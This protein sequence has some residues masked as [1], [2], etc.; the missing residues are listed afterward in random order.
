MTHKS[1]LL[2]GSALAPGRLALV[3]LVTLFALGQGV[4][5]EV[6][7]VV[8][9][10]D[11]DVSF[12]PDVFSAQ[13]G[14][15]I[16]DI[17]DPNSGVSINR[18]ERFDVDESGVVLNNSA[19]AG[20]SVLAGQIAANQNFS[21]NG[22][23][24]IVNEVA[25]SDGASLD[26]TVEVFGQNAD[27]IVASPNGI[28]CDGCAFI[29]TNAVTL[30]TGALNTSNGLVLEVTGGTVSVENGGLEADGSVRL[31]G[32]KAELNGVTRAAGDLIVSGGAQTFD[33]ITG[34]ASAR[35]GA[36]ATSQEYAVDGTSFGVAQAGQITVIGNEAGL[37]VRLL[38]AVQAG[39]GGF[40]AVSAGDLFARSVQTSGN[41]RLDAA[42]DI[43]IDRDVTS[44]G[45]TTV[46]AGGDVRLREDGGL[47]ASGLV[48][49]DGAG[50]VLIE[51][52]VQSFGGISAIAGVDLQSDG[53][54]TTLGV[55]SLQAQRN[56]DIAEGRVA[57]QSA[58]IAAGNVASIDNG[59]IDTVERVSVTGRDVALGQGA[60]FR[61]PDIMLTASEDFING[62]NLAGLGDTLSLSFGADLRNL[63]T[64]IFAFEQ[65]DLDL[66]GAILNEGLIFAQTDI[67]LRAAGLTNR[68]SG[69]I[70]A[71]NL[72]LDINGNLVN[73]GTIA[74]ADTL[75]LT[76]ASQLFNN[77]I[78]SAQTLSLMAGELTNTASGRLQSEAGALTLSL[79]TDLDNAGIIFS[80]EDLTIGLSGVLATNGVIA[81]N[82]DG[83]LDVGSFEG[84]IDNE[85]QAANLILNATANF[86]NRGVLATL[87]DIGIFT[88]GDFENFGQ[89][90]T[91]G[92]AE[93]FANS[94]LLSQTGGVQ[95]V[96]G[97]DFRSAD[98]FVQNGALFSGGR[99]RLE[100]GGTFAQAGQTVA[101]SALDISALSF[102]ST[103][104]AQLG[105]EDISLEIAQEVD[106]SGLL[107][108]DTINIIADEVDNSGTVQSET[109]LQLLIERLLENRGTGVLSSAGTAN[110][111][112]GSVVNNGQLASFG[113][114][115]LEAVGN[116]T[117]NGSVQSASHLSFL[118]DGLFLGATGLS[119]ADSLTASLGTLNNSGQLTAQ[120]DLSVS[121]GTFAQSGAGLVGAGGRVDIISGGFANSGLISAL[122]R[123]NLDIEIGENSGRLEAGDRI[124]L[125]ADGFENSASGIVSALDVSVMTDNILNRG[126]IVGSEL[127]LLGAENIISTGLIS[128]LSS[129]ELDGQAQDLGGIILGGLIDIDAQTVTF[130]GQ[131]EA[132]TGLSVLAGDE[133]LIE[134]VLGFAGAADFQ[135]DSFRSAAGSQLARFD[136]LRGEL[137][138]SA[139]G[140][141]DLDG[142]LF[143]DEVSVRGDTITT[144]TNSA[145]LAL[146]E[147]TLGAAGDLLVQGS[148]QAERISLIGEFVR[149]SEQSVFTGASEL[150]AQ[151]EQTKIDGRIE[152][153]LI[154]IL[155]DDVIFT[156][157][158]IVIG[159]EDLT[160]LADGDVLVAGILSAGEALTIGPDGPLA[161]VSSVTVS[162][163]VLAG[164]ALN[165]T[166]DSLINQGVLS[167]SVAS[168][169]L[170]VFEGMGASL[171]A[172]QTLSLA[173]NQSFHN[174]G[175]I[176][177]SGTATLSA[178]EIMTGS[179]SQI[180][181]AELVL[182][183]DERI[184]LDGSVVALELDLQ[185]PEL[186]LSGSVSTNDF[187]FSGVDFASI[188]GSR[189]EAAGRIDLDVERG[190]QI[191]GLLAAS[192]LTSLSA[193]TELN[194]AQTGRIESGGRL[195]VS[196]AGP[197]RLSG[198]VLGL[199]DI[200]LNASELVLDAGG[201]LG[202]I[203][204]DPM[205]AG[206]SISLALLGD[207]E[208]FGQISAGD[209]LIETG[210]DFFSRSGSLTQA[211]DN[212]SVIAPG[213]ISL[214]GTLLGE[215]S[216]VLDTPELMIL[217]GG[218][219]QVPVFDLVSLDAFSLDGSIIANDLS[220]EASSLTLGDEAAL[221][222]TNSLDIQLGAGAL[223]NAGELSGGTVS[224]EGASFVDDALTGNGSAIVFAQ[225]SL[226]GGFD[227]AD[228]S[229]VIG[230]SGTVDLDA[231]QVR[232]LASG[233]LL[234]GELDA[235]VER[236]FSN[237]GL[238]QAGR[239]DIR[240]DYFSLASGASLQA[241]SLTPGS[242]ILTADHV[243]IDG[244]VFS[245]D[246]LTIGQGPTASSVMAHALNG[247]VRAE[248]ELTLLGN[249]SQTGEVSSAGALFVIGDTFSQ[250]DTGLL[251]STTGVTIG[252]SGGEIMSAGAIASA[253]DVTLLGARFLQAE[254]GAI[255]S[256]SGAGTAISQLIIGTHADGFD[257]VDLDGVV[258]SSGVID[259]SSAQLNQSAGGQ[260][261]AGTEFRV[262]GDL[263]QSGTIN[264]GEDLT[265]T[266]SLIQASGGVLSAQLGD[267]LVRSGSADIE[268]SG[269]VVAGG[270]VTL[271]GSGLSQDAGGI[272]VS[273]FGSDQEAGSVSENRTVIDV[274]GGVLAVD[275]TVAGPDVEL[276]ADLLTLG[277]RTG[278]EDGLI[279]GDRNVTIMSALRQF[280][281]ITSNGTLTVQNGV[282]LD[283]E[284]NS[285]L[286]SADDLLVDIAGHITNDGTIAS[287]ADVTLNGGSLSQARDGVIVSNLNG[288]AD[289][290]SNDLTRINVGGGLLTLNGTISGPRVEI[291][292]GSIVLGAR[293]ADIGGLISAT[294]QL[295]ITGALTQSGV[296]TS[297][298]LLNINGPGFT[299]SAEGLLFSNGNLSI[300]VA[301]QI[302]TDGT[303]GS[304]ADVS[305]TGASLTQGRFGTIA[306][307]TGGSGGVTSL[308]AGAGAL[309]LNGT[310]TGS[311]VILEG[312]R[313]S[314]GP[315]INGV[316]GLILA[317]NDLDILLS[318]VL[319]SSGFIQV[320][321]PATLS[322]S[323]I[324]NTGSLVADSINVLNGS[325]LRNAGT[326]FTEGN[327]SIVNGGF[328][329]VNSGRL[330]VAGTGT[331]DID[332]ITNTGTI[333]ADTFNL[334]LD[335]SFQ[336]D[337]S[338][339]AINGLTVTTPGAI[340]NNQSLAANGSLTLNADSLRN[341]SGAV[342]QAGSVDIN[343]TQIA[344]SVIAPTQG[345]GDP[346]TSL[347]MLGLDLDGLLDFFINEFI[348]GNP[349][350]VPDS[351]LRQDLF[352][353]PP[354]CDELT[355]E[356]VFQSGQLSVMLEDLLLVET[357]Q[358]T[359]FAEEIGVTLASTL[360]PSISPQLENFVR[361]TFVDEVL[362]PSG[363]GT[364]DPANLLGPDPNRTID[365]TCTGS[366]CTISVNGFFVFPVEPANRIFFNVPL[367]EISAAATSRG[368]ALP[369]AAPTATTQND[370]LPGISSLSGRLAAGQ[371]VTL[372]SGDL[373][374]AGI[375]EA[376][377]TFDLFGMRLINGGDVSAFDTVADLSDVFDST[378]QSF[379]GTRLVDVTARR[380][381]GAG[382]NALVTDQ[383][384]AVEVLEGD[385]V[386]TDDLIVSGD[387]SL[388]TI[389]DIIFEADVGAFG[390]L[391]FNSGDD[392]VN[393]GADVLAAST[394]IA[395][396]N[397]LI[398][399]RGLFQA[400]SNIA[401]MASGL[402]NES[403]SV[404]QAGGTLNAQISDTTA[405]QGTLSGSVVS[406]S[407]TTILNGLNGFL[408]PGSAG[409]AAPNL[410]AGAGPAGEKSDTRAGTVDGPPL[411]IMGAD[412]PNPVLLDA[413]IA[414][415]SEE[416]TPL[417]T[418]PRA[419]V[420][421]G[422]ASF[423]PALGLGA[424]T[425]ALP[426]APALNQSPLA[427]LTGSVQNSVQPVLIE[428]GRMLAGLVGRAPEDIGFQTIAAEIDPVPGPAQA[429]SAEAVV[430]DGVDLPLE[431]IFEG[432]GPMPI[433]LLGPDVGLAGPAEPAAAAGM[434]LTPAMPVIPLPGVPEFG[435]DPVGDAAR[436]EME[437]FLAAGAGEMFDD[438]QGLRDIDDNGLV[439]IEGGTNF[440]VLRAY[441]D[442]PFGIVDNGTIIGENI[443][444]DAA[445]LFNAGTI[446]ASELVRLDGDSI[447]NLGGDILGDT[448]ALI[449]GGDVSNRFGDIIGGS[450]GIIADGD[451]LNDFSNL[452]S[453]IDDIFIDAGGDFSN[454][455]SGRINSATDLSIFA[456]GDILNEA[457]TIQF[458]LTEAHGCGG[459]ACGNLADDFLASEI[460]AGGNLL[461]SADGDINNIAS[462][463]GAVGDVNLRA[464]GDINNEA[465]TSV[466]TIVDINRRRGLFGRE[467]IRE[468][469]AIIRGGSVQAGG[470]LFVDADGDIVSSG[471]VFA[472]NG[473]TDLFALG[474]IVLNA[475]V[476]EL[477]FYE[478]Q[479]GF[480]GFTF[481]NVRTERNDFALELS[482]VIGENVF[483]SAGR[484]VTGAAAVV[485]AAND[486]SISAGRDISF[487][488]EQLEHFFEERGFSIGV[489]FTGS[490]LIETVI[491]GGSFNDVAG[492]FLSQNPF[493]N[494]LQRLAGSDTPFE[495]GF[496]ALNSATR[497][498]GFAQNVFGNGAGGIVDGLE[499]E[500]NPFSGV[501]LGEG[502]GSFVESLNI[503]LSFGSHR[504][505]Q[506]FT[507]SEFSSL[508]AGGNL[509][510]DAGQDINLIGGTDIDVAGDAFI[511]AGRDILLEAQADTFNERSSSFGGSVG[512]G[513]GG[514]TVGVNASNGRTDGTTF[515]PTT[516]DVGG[517]LTLISGQDTTLSG[518]RIEAASAAVL[519]GRDLTIETLQNLTE[520]RQSGFNASVTLAP[521]PTGGS[522]GVNASSQ[523]RQFSDNVS[524][525]VTDGALDV[526][527]GGTTSLIGAT[528]GSRSEDFRLSTEELITQDLADSDRSRSFSAGGSIGGLDEGLNFRTFT[529]VNGSFSTA[530][531]EGTTFAT[532]GQGEITIGG[533]T[534]EAIAD[535][536]AGLNRD[537]EEV[538][539]ITRQTSF[540]TGDLELDVKSLGQAID[541]LSDLLTPEELAEVAENLGRVENFGPHLEMLLEDVPDD[542]KAALTELSEQYINEQRNKAE[543]DR[544]TFQD[545]LNQLDDSTAGDLQQQLIALR[546]SRDES[547][548]ALLREL[549]A[550]NN[551]QADAVLKLI[552][553]RVIAQRRRAAA[554][555]ASEQQRI[556]DDI[557]RRTAANNTPEALERDQEM[558]NR[559]AQQRELERVRLHRESLCAIYECSASDSLNPASVDELTF[560][561]LENV[562]ASLLGQVVGAGET[563]IALVRDGG[564]LAGIVALAG[565]GVP[566]AQK[567]LAKRIGTTVD[568]AIA[569][570][571][572]V[573]E[574]P[575][576]LAR[577]LEAEIARREQE[578]QDADSA[579]E[580]GRSQGDLLLDALLTV[581]TGG[582]S[583]AVRVGTRVGD[584][585][586]T[587][588]GQSDSDGKD[589]EPANDN[590]VPEE[591][592]APRPTGTCSFRGD[593]LVATSVG[594]TEIQHIRAGMSV[595]SRNPETGEVGLRTVSAQYSNAYPETVYIT[596]IDAETGATQTIVSNRIHPMFVQTLREGISSSEGH[597]Y[598]GSIENGH[599]IDAA[600]LQ[601][602]DRLLNDDGSWAEVAS[603]TLEAEALV[604][605]NL[606]VNDWH[607]YFVAGDADAEP[608]WVHNNCF[609]AD[610]IGGDF[611][612]LR[613]TGTTPDGRAV[614]EF[615]GENGDTRRLYQGDDGR[616][617]DL[618]VIPP[619]NPNLSGPRKPVR[620][621]DDPE[622][623]RG[624]QRENDSA[625][626]LASD[627]RMVEQLSDAGGVRG[628]GNDFRIN[629]VEFDNVA[630]GSISLRNTISK[631]RDKVRDGKPNVVINL[632]DSPHS[633][634]D[635]RAQLREFP[636]PG[637]QRLI[638]IDRSGRIHN[639][640]GD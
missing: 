257:L 484:D 255:A 64:G 620:S 179:S 253:G 594:Y 156:E 153:N 580:A 102:E 233:Q 305:L 60:L 559:L 486:L 441:L 426:A 610:D 281:T 143:A 341:N 554:Q 468:E 58:V 406:V 72:I 259:I 68:L 209:L 535:Q 628:A 357:R 109:A 314:L 51:G 304:L 437:G 261:A 609:D 84:L 150:F 8:V 59:F 173:A 87:S 266:G 142:I 613:Q 443:F 342:I 214:A 530:T 268:A 292:A 358:V 21:G 197:V 110:V 278:E 591:A 462:N 590:E 523:D 291:D 123:L 566:G 215:G 404:V 541:D 16:V 9:D 513:P 549:T 369:A 289:I 446:D 19:T 251:F 188:D 45:D 256:G 617:Y 458:R 636:A 399:N 208:T 586:D 567:E 148:G 493:T 487:G 402:Q 459:R 306:S 287:D 616:F 370:A 398:V 464:I 285:V 34:A 172:A 439:T 309:I 354:A 373:L 515:T 2:S 140:D 600:D 223:V 297:G 53:I 548:I 315:R 467:I 505:R 364:G 271:I 481:S 4:S 308:N 126:Q 557:A 7:G 593:M 200:E 280:G 376:A 440:D 20:E 531:T 184:A 366:V 329:L 453:D 125:M 246:D 356:A 128:A 248:G 415:L 30:S 368:I 571:V 421:S 551:E 539:I 31:V 171:L 26:G 522:F 163:Q 330:T 244:T 632:A 447:T 327:F 516:L 623:R 158:A 307:G 221:I 528:L 602:G 145:L 605:Y 469:A 101:V 375:I 403:G 170:G 324:T 615:T 226:V 237:F 337:G 230:S 379:G 461:L 326:I 177:V 362:L 466:F 508:T 603:V 194:I 450:V 176:G 492:S 107:V 40:S 201:I 29:N 1:K 139:V 599:W 380:L 12:Q 5:Q 510:L 235:D 392:I 321:G 54:L 13:N 310:I 277:P 460:A 79:L 85:V 218:V 55:V 532:L 98:G 360:V 269:A 80:A 193:D 141:V 260:I 149:L 333:E 504:T 133:I 161:S 431:V 475:A 454:R 338:L 542:L 635:I 111:I 436:S 561:I 96:A 247:V 433:L 633:V 24:V 265:I 217:Q 381:V 430:I 164:E 286:F 100:A 371:S 512:L 160:L 604:A 527:V 629:G 46:A 335:R 386:I 544:Q 491:N 568:G 331:F 470:N 32:R 52:E 180:E 206:G 448:I 503:T 401:L 391:V 159:L 537:L 243:V 252:V 432:S 134:G 212:L 74:A 227:T 435:A 597:V 147:L 334:T 319:D 509:F 587:N 634:R 62:A 480:S 276:I 346:F 630:P 6:G 411:T 355:C 451:V 545:Y 536:L 165:L 408:R 584:K 224:I 575:A 614:R 418:F 294:T 638:V 496:N 14:V 483:L 37:G 562:S 219:L 410:R 108:G 162:G 569:L 290:A 519:V 196:S 378:A 578:V 363:R 520:S 169:D 56:V 382:I 234:A 103:I 574:D 387:I 581:A 420:P 601:S 452:V 300:E 607:T 344:R 353:S 349:G 311:S 489:S 105:G 350:L 11:A 81:A 272:I 524:G 425:E 606:T 543:G 502:A 500:L 312:G 397:N 228:V 254:T 456:A 48:G 131:L 449:A 83:Q 485:A 241:T 204:S 90:Q 137:S 348:P 175:D 563:G 572:A 279:S 423:G 514:V 540:S 262:S 365:I 474:D 457:Q 419:P 565:L 347:G 238:I 284:A 17:T 213:Q 82:G 313:L 445:E 442:E 191:A 517:H 65:I 154:S 328:N 283:Q 395:D 73:D 38:G 127:D 36:P 497:G 583:T 352:R 560:A 611:G 506:D 626:I 409:V 295:D 106:H 416:L 76:V 490:D 182:L 384:L 178:A 396:A 25:S 130:A 428:R 521:A 598:T 250:T 27:L 555:L 507:E 588:G 95:A 49:I 476:E 216:V 323:R 385:I 57:G 152:S 619:T 301:G 427:P 592:E 477:E 579:F 553:V 220:L 210:G 637:L 174:D 339:I 405:N 518:A 499:S 494:S 97:I 239:F 225:D 552:E 124:D 413:D 564:E 249:F 501:A 538:Q 242:N 585:P 340:I 92:A 23:D 115:R 547:D 35:A 302:L 422:T 190:F 120:G 186:V 113:D 343:L 316:G 136:G 129:L 332:R 155:S 157:T 389:A 282:F 288:P 526:E 47:F 94:V 41:T 207:L 22:A 383:N 258:S 91:D 104:S 70:F 495:I 372:T 556:E 429:G 229:G 10:P 361:N 39:D 424:M 236:V 3:G 121:S 77:G 345:G 434:D 187:V 245:A 114:F 33:A 93:I 112:A 471:S 86:S 15:T 573:A 273:N 267:V 631:A 299:Q 498:N 529:G 612:A 482:Q 18:F 596:A 69:Q 151:A 28:S 317:D 639:V 44:R 270:D 444:L 222:G 640:I 414:D 195:D 412:V 263:T 135:S 407:S 99:I 608:V 570:A 478:K 78:L 359:D 89:I 511:R 185:T 71:Q 367:S 473:T 351:A 166:S 240:A 168:L 390:N 488:A 203:N 198:T 88:G 417:G 577:A 550:F 546:N 296:I 472:S 118:A 122:E 199:D 394:I 438:L 595:V 589:S 67:M 293:T 202:A 388:T 75:N 43:E 232:L 66:N 377:G 533:Q 374:N 627:G 61:S 264:A 320:G 298:G 621:Q 534:G 183:G 325:E 192:G 231:G 146:G 63:A 275:G 625:D 138:V 322:A 463:I 558:R 582:T 465:L 393:E 525:I 336:N 50:T 167:G 205:L 116:I 303:I 144:Q 181:A 455:N 117:N 618:D 624:A 189:V 576:V 274:S 479:K 132:A 622:T 42:G 400:G 119:S 318:G 211:S